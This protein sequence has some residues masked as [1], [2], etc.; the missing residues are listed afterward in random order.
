MIFQCRKV[1]TLRYEFLHLRPHLRPETA[2][3]ALLTRHPLL[4]QARML[5]HWVLVWANTFAH[6]FVYGYFFCA[7]M[8]I[9]VGSTFK[10]AITIIQIGQFV[11]DML[12]SLPFPI[13]K[14]NGTTKGEWGP[15]I[16][17]QFIGFTF[18]VLFSRVYLQNKEKARLRKLDGKNKALQ[19]KSKKEQ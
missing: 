7:T 10:S 11:L 9:E 19:T 2:I 6:I 5:N 3:H 15:W 18:I 14:M 8:K 12:Y 1:C 17:G 16:M 4:L 13:Y